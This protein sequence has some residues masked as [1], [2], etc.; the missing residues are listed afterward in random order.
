MQAQRAGRQTASRDSAAEEGACGVADCCQSEG[1]GQACPGDNFVVGV[2]SGNFVFRDG[3]SF[4]LFNNGAIKD[5]D[6]LTCEDPALDG[7][8]GTMDHDVSFSTSLST[9]ES[10][11]VG[12]GTCKVTANYAITIVN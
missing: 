3:E 4:T 1:D 10:V 5:H 6:N 11:D 9:S 2:G 7:T 8:I 12:S